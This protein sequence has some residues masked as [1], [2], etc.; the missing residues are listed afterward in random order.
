MEC[1]RRKPVL[2]LSGDIHMFNR[3]RYCQT[4]GGVA[5]GCFPAVAT[6][7]LTRSSTALHDP[8]LTIF[9]TVLSW[10]LPVSFT[11]APSPD[12]DLPVRRWHADLE[13]MLLL[14]N[15][16]I[17]EWGPGQP[18]RVQPLVRKPALMAWGYHLLAVTLG[19]W[20]WLLLA[21]ALMLLALPVGCLLA[22]VGGG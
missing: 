18:L 4:V 14:N 1:H 10:L 11:I 22:H 13:A 8:K 7:G 16:V 12:T 15:A 21:L 3:M 5:Q 2:A 19:G 17:L 6:S 9:N 20:A